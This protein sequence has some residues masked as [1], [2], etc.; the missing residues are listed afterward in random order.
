[1]FFTVYAGEATQKLNKRVNCHRTGF[2]QPSNRNSVV[3]YQ[4][5]LTYSFQILVKLEGNGR[6]AGNALNIPITTKRKQC[7]KK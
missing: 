5:F 2:N 6:K 1:M 7:E 3:F 4:I